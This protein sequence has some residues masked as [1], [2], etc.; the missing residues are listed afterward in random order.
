MFLLEELP[1]SWGIKPSKSTEK[2]NNRN[3]KMEI[4]WAS[5]LAHNFI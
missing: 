3:S 1:P 5:H 2:I 4:I